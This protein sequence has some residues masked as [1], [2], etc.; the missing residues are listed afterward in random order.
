MTKEN[1]MVE[2]VAEAI[3]LAHPMAWEGDGVTPA[4]WEFGC[5]AY[6]DDYRKAAR[7]AIQAMRE[8]TQEMRD[9]GFEAGDIEDL[10]W[11]AMIDEALK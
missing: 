1:Q 6:A 7:A 5:R 10:V 9:A 4:S 8:S 11:V 2:R 3:W